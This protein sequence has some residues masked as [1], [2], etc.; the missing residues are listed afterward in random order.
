MRKQAQSC[1]LKHIP[2]PQH[3]PGAQRNHCSTTIATWHSDCTTLTAAAIPHSDHHTATA[4]LQ[5]QRNRCTSLD[6]TRLRLSLD[7][8]RLDS[9]STRL[10]STR[11]RLD[12]TST[13]PDWTRCQ[14]DLTRLGSMSTRLHSTRLGF[15]STRFGVDPT[16]CRLDSTR[17]A[18]SIRV[19][20][21]SAR[22][23]IDSTLLGFGFESMRF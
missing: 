18:A 15:D 9:M 14:L 4:P 11:L 13:R 6:S 8:T 12:S 20:F 10:D 3:T 21:D 1:Y 16:P 2:A 5:S 17:H 7:S 22:F 23:R 19:S